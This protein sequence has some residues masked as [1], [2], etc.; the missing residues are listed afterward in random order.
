MQHRLYGLRGKA[1]VAK[2]LSDMSREGLTEPAGIPA[3]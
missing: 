1:F 2:Y 3:F